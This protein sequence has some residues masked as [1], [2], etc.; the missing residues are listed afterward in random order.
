M[1]GQ[2]P[3]WCPAGV[4]TRPPS[5]PPTQKWSTMSVQPEIFADAHALGSAAA[6]LFL[7][8]LTDHPP[9][10]PFLLGC[11]GGR[12][13][14]STYAAIG[15]AAASRDIDLSRVVIVMM[16]EYVTAL[17]DGSFDS[18][19][20]AELHSC[21]RFAEREILA[22]INAGLPSGHVIPSDHLWVPGPEDPSGYERRLQAAN[23]VDLFLLA[24]GAG[25]GHVAFNPPGSERDSRTRIVDLPESTRRDNLATFPSFGGVVDRVPVH[26]VSVGIATIRELS[27]EVVM[28]LH[29][30][31]KRTAVQRLLAADSY[32][33]TWPATVLTECRQAHLYIDRLALSDHHL[34]ESLIRKVR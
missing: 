14:R 4:K 5:R 2:P 34:E 7:T 18:V 28:L 24:S 19:D 27:S 21:R 12:S 23:G 29:G 25:D 8:R 22:V 31:D 32:D 1:L 20:P 26:G 33:P 13:P 17:P 6:A 11:P 3:V 9:D 10:Q 16:D 15:R 30:R